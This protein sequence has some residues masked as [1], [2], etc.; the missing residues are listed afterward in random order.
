LDVDA[1]RP[2]ASNDAPGIVPARR[3]SGHRIRRLMTGMVLAMLV[4]A[5]G[6]MPT[7]ARTMSQADRVVR[8]VTSHIGARYVWGSTGPRGFDCSGL[9]YRAFREAH[10]AR[11][12]GGFNTAH[13]YYSRFRHLG[14]VSRSAPRVGDIVV[15]N[16]GGHVGI[17]VG[18]GMVV[19]A[20]LRG[21]TRHPIRGLEIPFTAILRVNLGRH[22]SDYGH[23][24]P[25]SA[26]SKTK[27]SHKSGH[28]HPSHKV[29]RKA[30][31]RLPLRADPSRGSDALRSLKRGTRMVV[32]ATRNKHHGPSW[33]K[34][35]LG[36]GD[37]GWVNRSLTRAA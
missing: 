1:H 3:T 32:L 37:R 20:L 15:Y 6:A 8:A 27:S 36:N 2:C 35:R 12:I 9:V 4:L 21:V 16:N 18:H 17:Y 28:H 10:V 30:T 19:S 11:A 24:V 29:V 23:L 33:V 25:A 31:Q 26:R 13:G 7:S 22:S 5:A 34:V 14:R